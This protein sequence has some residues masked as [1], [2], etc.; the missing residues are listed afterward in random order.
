M[1]IAVTAIA[2]NKCQFRESTFTKHRLVM[3]EELH[4]PSTKSF[5]LSGHL[6]PTP[7]FQPET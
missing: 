1:F 3:L 2:C 5:T 7:V 6:R 4:F